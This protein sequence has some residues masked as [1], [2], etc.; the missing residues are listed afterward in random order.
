MRI[1]LIIF[2]S[3]ILKEESSCSDSEEAKSFAS[4]GKKTADRRP[5]T[6]H[7]TTNDQRRKLLDYIALRGY[8]VLKVRNN[9]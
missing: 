5:K 9:P 4:H 1:H 8:S 3:Q 6:Y 7:L 2:M